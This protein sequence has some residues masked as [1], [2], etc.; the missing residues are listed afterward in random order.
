MEMSSILQRNLQIYDFL[1]IENKNYFSK[2]FHWRD[3]HLLEINQES[4]QST[5]SKIIP[6]ITQ[7]GK[8]ERVKWKIV[9]NPKGRT[10]RIDCEV[11]VFLII[12]QSTYLCE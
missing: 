5:P 8:L 2:S 1:D 11:I 6:K 7:K 3:P 10:C 4:E 12:Y 9:D